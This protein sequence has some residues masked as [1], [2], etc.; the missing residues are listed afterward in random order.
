[1]KEVDVKLPEGLLGNRQFIPLD[2]GD[3]LACIA[4]LAQALG[5]R[6]MRRIRLDPA[7][8]ALRADLW[9][10]RNTP[11]F[12]VRY[13]TQDSEGLESSFRDGRLELVDQGFYLNVAGVPHRAYVDV[14]GL[15]NG[16]VRFSS[17]WVSADAVQVKIF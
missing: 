7:T 15:L 2:Q 11:G 1:V 10:L 12:L 4:E 8:D 13:R 14:E 3:R 16:V 6:G 5:Q 17:G 9:G